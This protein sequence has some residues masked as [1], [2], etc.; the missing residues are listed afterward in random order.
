MAQQLTTSNNLDIDTA[1]ATI[2][3]VLHNNKPLYCHLLLFILNCSSF[4]SIKEAMIEICSTF[5]DE[6][7]SHT[8]VGLPQSMEKTK[9]LMATPTNDTNFQN[10]GSSYNFCKKKN[11]TEEQCWEKKSYININYI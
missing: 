8:P 7:I 5:P 6:I 10:K 9:I 4:K 2:L 1:K 3:S 11:H